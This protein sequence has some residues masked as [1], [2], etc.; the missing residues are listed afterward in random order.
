MKVN[1]GSALLKCR[2]GGDA[3]NAEDGRC[4]IAKV[5]AD[6]GVAAACVAEAEI[7]EQASGEGVG[8]IEDSLLA[9]HVGEARD[10]AGSKDRAGDETASV[11]Q[12]A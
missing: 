11:G 10:A 7:V 12:R 1:S 2:V 6:D 5:C 9:K 4:C 3:G 8:L